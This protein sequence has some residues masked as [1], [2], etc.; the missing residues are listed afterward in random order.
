MGRKYRRAGDIVS[1]KK[2]ATVQGSLRI[3]GFKC[4]VAKPQ[5][6]EIIDKLISFRIPDTWEDIDELA[7]ED[8]TVKDLAKDSMEWKSIEGK[9][10]STMTTAQLIKIE[11]IQNK[12]LWQL[13]QIEVDNITRK[14][15]LDALQME[16]FH[17]TSKTSPDLIYKG[18]E[19]FQKEYCNDGMWGIA[20]YFA[21]KSSYS[22]GYSF[23]KETGERQMFMATVNVGNTIQLNT[24]RTLKMP[25]L[26]PNSQANRYDS[27]KGFTGNSDVY[28]V[29]TNKKAYP[30]YLI[31]Y[32]V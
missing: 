23:K 32:K 9:F 3:T 24:D 15:N 5:I 27:V 30:S 20:N 6:S 14:N 16:L 2:S 13:Y 18:E 7:S 19:G 25:P 28:M 1:I 26:L 17:G 29:Y 10:L 21:V 4:K 11:R 8:L 31:T 12:K 22:N